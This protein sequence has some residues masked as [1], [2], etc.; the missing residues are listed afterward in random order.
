MSN[1][2]HFQVCHIYFSSLIVCLPCLICVTFLLYSLLT[3][4]FVFHFCILQSLFFISNSTTVPFHFCAWNSFSLSLPPLFLYL[5]YPLVCLTTLS[6]TPTPLVITD[7]CYLCT[8][9]HSI[10]V[11]RTSV[12]ASFLF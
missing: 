7:I 3:C 2:L 11:Q 9:S 10:S 8:T 1:L 4:P 6:S 12:Y 5:F